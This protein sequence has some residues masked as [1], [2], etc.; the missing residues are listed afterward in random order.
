MIKSLTKA[1]EVE[2][3]KRLGRYSAK[4]HF[5]IRDAA[6]F[7]KRTGLKPKI[8]ASGTPAIWAAHK[9]FDPRYCANHARFLAKGIWTSL[10]AKAYTPQPAIR[11]EI[12]KPAGGTRQIDVFSIPDAAVAKLFLHRLRG[13]N[14][15]VF[16]DASFA[17][18]AKKTPLDAVFR[19]RSHLRAPKIF[20][21]QYDFSS[22]FDSISHDHVRSLLAKRRL[23]LTTHME[24][25]VLSSVL[26]HR[27]ASLSDYASGS[28]STRLRGTPQGNSV[29][30]FI[31][32]AVAHELDLSLSRL[33]GSFARFA[34]DSV[35]VNYTYEDAVEC[36]SV[37]SS[38]TD[39]SG[40]SINETKSKGIRLFAKSDGELSTI[41]SFD[42]LSYKFTP[43]ALDVSSKGVD[44]I[45]TRCGKIIYNNLL[46]HPKRTG[47]IHRRR[48]G[49]GFVDWD[50]VTCV[51]E[52]RR[53][54]YGDLSSQQIDDFLADK[55]N[56]RAGS[57]AVSYY[58]LVDSGSVFRQLDGWLV[59][60]LGRAHTERRKIARA[61]R[62]KLGPIGR[63]DL[64]TG[65]WYVY[66]PIPMDL[67]LPSF[68][69]AW[70]AARKT[71][72]RHGLGSITSGP[73]GYG[74][75]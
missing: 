52:L 29:S 7:Q 44:Y 43:S 24:R 23:L 8:A 10:N 72:E 70:R 19:L 33:N 37:F 40:I 5:A 20:L 22:Y 65:G 42:F 16:S 66:P 4:R 25:Q 62:L 17:Y 36:A 1:I 74:Y 67:R 6:T 3:K 60:V 59:D 41:N 49:T 53:Y 54:I 57:G 56:V 31:A 34:D 30:L 45:K 50:L 26:T 51:N 55:T 18:Q 32:N 73:G 27:Y 11:F 12:P 47:K 69:S 21:S 46:L 39:S 63:T 75:T 28:F 13:R 68:H 71:W 48:I 15:K 38:F 9:H 2:A 64:L 14:A 61:L 35:V 58:C